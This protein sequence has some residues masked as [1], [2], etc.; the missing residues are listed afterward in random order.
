M[1]WG[2]HR[3]YDVGLLDLVPR[4]QHPEGGWQGHLRHGL[5]GTP[6]LTKVK[7][8]NHKL[9]AIKHVLQDKR[10]K[11]REMEIT[12]KL[13]HSNIVKLEDFFYTTQGNVTQSTLRN[14]T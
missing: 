2:S 7:D 13:I 6:A 5:S 1:G 3:Y 12:A 11:N 9:F 8:S 4:L 14:S 10:Y